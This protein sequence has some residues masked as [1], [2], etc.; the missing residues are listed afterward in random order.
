L[1]NDPTSHPADKLKVLE[2]AAEWCSVFGYP[3]PSS[4][5]ADEV[6]DNYILPDMMTNAATGKM[7]PEEAVKWAA[8]EIGLIYAKWATRT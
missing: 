6:A 7:T 8:K 5:A 3:G 4:P 2:T 1:S